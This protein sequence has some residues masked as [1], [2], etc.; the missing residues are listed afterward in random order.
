MNLFPLLR[1]RNSTR[2]FDSLTPSRRD[3]E[4]Y[5]RGEAPVLPFKGF[6][7]QTE[8]AFRSQTGQLEGEVRRQVNPAGAASRLAGR[9]MAKEEELVRA[10]ERRGRVLRSDS[11]TAAPSPAAPVRTAD[12]YLRRSPVQ[13]VYEAPDYRRRMLLRAVG[14]VIAA[15]VILF[16]LNYLLHSRLS[17]W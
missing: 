10:G 12:G 2:F 17:I 8:A 15:A 11:G 5:R 16:L 6:R 14:A 7:R 1:K 4:I 13:P 3:G 9:A